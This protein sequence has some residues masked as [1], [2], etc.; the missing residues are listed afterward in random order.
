MEYI[1][2]RTNTRMLADVFSIKNKDLSKYLLAMVYVMPI[3]TYK[4]GLVQM[5][6]ST[7]IL[8]ALLILFFYDDFYLALPILIFFYIQLVLP[9][10]IALFRVYSILFILKAIS[11]KIKIDI[12]TLFP[13]IIIT[14]YSAFAIVPINLRTAVFIIFDMVF[15]IL[16]VKI[17]LSNK[18]KFSSFFKFY[19]IAALVA[20]AFGALRMTGQ[21]NTAV[22]VDGKWVYITR[23]IAT[24]NDP[25][26]LGFFF[27]IAIFA[28]ISLKIFKSKKVQNLF[29]IILYFALIATLSTTAILCNVLGIFIYLILSKKIN[30]KTATVVMLIILIITLAYNTALSRPVPLLSDAAMKMKSKVSEL[31]DQNLSSFTSQRT[32]IWEKHLKVFWNQSNLKILLGGNVITSYVYDT[33]KF[34]TVSHQEIIDMLLNFGL[35]GT[36]AMLLSYFANALKI[37]FNLVQNRNEQDVMRLMI[38]YVWIFYAFGLTMFPGWMFYLFFFI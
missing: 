27:N 9:G 5:L 23:F 22:Y 32:D 6:A 7:V 2:K 29:L 36:L 8:M 25:N 14:L 30:L 16:Y 21:L 10:G 37:L 24:Y 4:E 38:K 11:V 13:L 31:E 20:T 28:A 17:C 26:Y 1:K 35:L 15:L 33:T 12:P 34:K 18:E 19:I 3:F